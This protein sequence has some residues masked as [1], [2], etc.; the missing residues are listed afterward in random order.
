MRKTACIL[1]LLFIM[2]SLIFSSRGE[3]NAVNLKLRVT[4]SVANIRSGP[5]L[6]YKIIMQVKDGTILNAI[7]KKGNWYLVILSQQEIKPPL[8]GYIHQ[9]IVELVNEPESM[10]EPAKA[11]PEE[12]PEEKVSP[13]IFETKPKPE[14][15]APQYPRNIYSKKIYIRASYSLGFLKEISSSV[16]QETIYHETANANVDYNIQKGNFFSAAFGYRVYGPLS[17]EVGMD[18]TSRNMDGSYS[19]LIPHPLL[20]GVSRNGGGIE[21]YKLSENSIFLNLVYSFRSGK[22]GLD[23]SAGP[24]YIL[25]KTKVISGI[26][27]TDSYP[28]DSVTLS[29]DNTDVSKNVFG[30][31]GGV[32]MLFY[33]AENF[34]IDFNA[35][36][37]Y[38]KADFET[39]TGIPSPQITLG[40]LKAGAGLKIQF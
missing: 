34:A 2:P 12:Q 6:D 15:A 26:A 4:A 38:G 3:S 18:I 11:E 31:N 7:G 14:P 29:P 40:G 9:I 24:A 36:Y 8:N 23:F 20:F 13:Q 37:I 35:H 1:F 28:Y 32:D 21:A 39:G 16:W 5:S 22:F 33:L 19:A 25:S 30:F 10:P 17:L 27:Y